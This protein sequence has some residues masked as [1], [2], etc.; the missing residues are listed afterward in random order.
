MKLFNTKYFLSAAVSLLCIQHTFSQAIVEGTVL[1]NKR[2][3]MNAATILIKPDSIGT[4]AD[5]AGHF[6]FRSIAKGRKTLQV[7]SVGYVTREIEINTSDSLIHLA[8][9]LKDES[10]TLGEVV[11]SA[12]S[13]EASDKAKGASLT[14][15]DAV[16]V[17]GNGGDIQDF[18]ND[19]FHLV[20]FNIYKKIIL[21]SFYCT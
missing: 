6:S 15:I 21:V 14:P 9:I 1:N 10:K 4:N 5:S 17:A 11:V 8:I 18:R 7:S 3:P 16:T 2:E 19:N 20:I 13:F 12:G